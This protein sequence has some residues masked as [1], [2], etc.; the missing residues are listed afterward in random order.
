VLVV[1]DNQGLTPHFSDVVGRFAGAG[2][3]AL[4]VD[5]LSGDGGHATDPS[6]APMALATLP[7]EKLIASMRAG[8]VELGRRTP[9]VKIG[10]VGFGFG[11]GALWQ[12]LGAGDPILAAA[13]PFY[14]STPDDVDFSKSHAAILALYPENDRK[15]GE[16]QDN[17]DMAMMKANLVHNSTLYPDAAAGFFDDTGAHYN[18]DA[19]AKGWQATLDWFNQY[20]VTA[21]TASP[22]PSRAPNAHPT[23]APK[24]PRVP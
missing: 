8:V 10:A 11:A 24:T 23:T 7:P 14:G 18:A 5:L 17:A 1:H 22:A 3:A 16:S 21:P 6:Q 9:G 19:A 15:L 13:V 2:Y 12:I 4:C 20:L